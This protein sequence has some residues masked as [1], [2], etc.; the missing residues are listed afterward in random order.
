MNITLTNY[1]SALPIAVEYKS[2]G[3]SPLDFS[4]PFEIT[5]TT[6]SFN[7]SDFQSA[8]MPVGYEL[9]IIVKQNDT[10]IYR[11]YHIIN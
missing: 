11:E 5:D 4:I 8:G 1:N 3:L 2:L 6:L 7:D 9:Y 10:E